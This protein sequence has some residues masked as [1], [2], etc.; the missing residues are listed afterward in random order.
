MKT[1][2]RSRLP[3]FWRGM[4]WSAKAAWLVTARL[5]SSYSEACSMMAKLPSKPT[6]RAVVADYW[7]N[8]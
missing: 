3:H 1:I 4:S 2:D 6:A 5:A 7:W 8:K